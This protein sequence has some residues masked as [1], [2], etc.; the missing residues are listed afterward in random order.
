MAAVATAVATKT[1]RAAVTAVTN[2]AAA[3]AT[4]AN[5]GNPIDDGSNINNS[6]SS[7]SADDIRNSS[8]TGTSIDDRSSIA[9]STKKNVSGSAGDAGSGSRKNDKYH[10]GLESLGEKDFASC[11]DGG[12]TF[13][14][15]GSSSTSTSTNRG[16]NSNNASIERT[17]MSSDTKKVAMRPATSA[18]AA[19]AARATTPH[20]PLI[21][22][23]A[24]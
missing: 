18:V 23:R 7:G 13:D 6:N 5:I 20:R 11:G 22:T 10:R 17:V 16:S 2:A 21:S 14:K 9:K 1:P 24:E 12:A 19:A 15:S 4:A 3:A 8:N